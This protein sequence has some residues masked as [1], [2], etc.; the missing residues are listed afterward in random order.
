MSITVLALN[1]T[2]HTLANSGSDEVSFQKDWKSN[3]HQTKANRNL[4]V[5]YACL[6]T[7][8][9]CHV[10]SASH[11]PLIPQR[12]LVAATDTLVAIG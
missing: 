7:H 1:F 3:F 6:E 2:D 5:D 8:S 10:E 11:L 9:L 12:E 4:A